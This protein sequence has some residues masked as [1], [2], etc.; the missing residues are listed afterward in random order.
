MRL[1]V[2]LA[3][4][5]AGAPV[6]AQQDRQ[7]WT[8]VVASGPVRGELALF[9]YVEIHLEDDASRLG[10]TQLGAGLGW[11][12][13]ERFSLYGGY[14]LVTTHRPGAA[15]L[16]EHRL[17]QQASYALGAIGPV[18]LSGRTGIEERMFEGS[19]DLGWRLQQRVRATLPV[20]HGRAR[21]VAFAEMLFNLNDTDWG[22]RAGPAQARG[23]GGVN[24]PVGHRESVEFGYFHQRILREGAPDR[25]NHVGLVTFSYRL[26]R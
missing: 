21:L 15:D 26:G 16:K 17:W 11:V 23:F 14:F 13:S 25:I 22:A 2:P 6:R 8:A 3:M 12:P 24:L 5:L 4:L 10:E 7:F 19:H 1:A 9:V 20:A 18:R